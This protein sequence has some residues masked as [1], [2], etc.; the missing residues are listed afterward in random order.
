AA[1]SR[2]TR[3]MRSLRLFV[4]ALA[5]AAPLAAQQ[6][7]Q[8]R[9]DLAALA[10]IREEG[11]SRSHMDSLAGYLTDVIGPRLTA[12]SNLRRAQEWAAQTFRSWGMANVNI[13][14]WD[15]LFGRGWERVSFA[16]RMVEPY[17]Q[18]LN[19]VAQ[20]WT[21]S[22]RGTVT[23][24]VMVVTV[25]ADSDMTQYS[26][27]LRGACIMRAAP[28]AITPE[29]TPPARR[30][31][32]DSLIAIANR[33]LAN[34]PGAAPQ[35]NPQAAETRRQQQAF[36][37]RLYAWFQ[38]Q[39]VV[40]A[41]N[42]SNWGFGMLLTGGGPQSRQARDSVNFEPLPSLT[43]SNEHYGQLWRDVRRNVPVRLELNVQN[44]FTNPD[45]REYNV[46][47]EIP[48]TDRAGEVVMVGAHYDSW[49]PGTGAT[50]NGAGS[51]VMME[52]MRLLKTL[53]L[54]MRRTVRIALW[55]GEEQGL[56]GSRDWVRKHR[57]DLASISAYLNVDNGTGRLRGVYAQSNPDVMPIFENI[58]S[59][60]R[61]LGV[62]TM[63]PGNTGGTDHLSFDAAGVPGFQFIQDPMDY[64]T[65][66][67][68]SN[69]DTY[70]RLVMD[71]LKQAATIVAWSVYT[72]ANRDEMMPRKPMAGAT[73]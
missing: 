19:A 50:D 22:T 7:V 27:R 51:V 65:R 54:P 17:P 29:W 30:F 42:G 62:V 18:P 8:E 20:A 21:G 15:S 55:S 71:D 45:R 49:H 3:T 66:T 56:L 37:A 69:L 33:A 31:D 5:C 57:A 44:R 72:I 12:S 2:E 73:N 46:I 35:A 13:E 48:G 64:D 34:R 60:F 16:G 61:D 70:E 10:R 47:A 68:H 23:C 32:A 63:T 28:R 59:P 40:A 36:E 25:V 52:A 6:V 41:L 38:Q 53:N 4:V 43:L 58:L 11:L 14:P 24:P 26:G 1:S 39:G 9:L 67:H